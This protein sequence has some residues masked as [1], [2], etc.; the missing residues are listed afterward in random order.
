MAGNKP[1]RNS[2]RSGNKEFCEADAGCFVENDV[3]ELG[4]ERQTGND[5]EK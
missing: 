1:N 4:I 2:R 5:K 3:L